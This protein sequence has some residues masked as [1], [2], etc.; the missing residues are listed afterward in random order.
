MKTRK[1]KLFIPVLAVMFAVTSAFSTSANSNAEDSTTLDGYIDAPTPCMIAISC[2]PAGSQ[3]CKTQSG[4]QVF[5]KFNTE[6]TT[7]LREVYKN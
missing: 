1:I 7:C 4:E 3:V 2:L 5:G 6:D